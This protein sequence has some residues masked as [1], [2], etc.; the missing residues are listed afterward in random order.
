MP[1]MMQRRANATKAWIDRSDSNRFQTALLLQ[2]VLDEN[3]HDLSRGASVNQSIIQIGVRKKK[4]WN[5][6]LSLVI[7]SYLGM[8][9]A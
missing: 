9:H 4:I 1:E 6:I 7:I 2:A 8:F 5:D 3:G